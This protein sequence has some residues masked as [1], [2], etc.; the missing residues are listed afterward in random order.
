MFL[1]LWIAWAGLNMVRKQA[2]MMTKMLKHKIIDAHPDKSGCLLLGS[3]SFTNRMEQELK[4]DPIWFS[5]FRMKIKT[6]EKYLGQVIKSSLS[7]SALATAQDRAGKIK[8]AAIEIKQIIE[9]YQMQAIG[10]LAA[11]WVLWERAFIPSLLAGA[12]TWL[13]DIQEA[14][15][16]CNTIQEFYWKT[17]LKVLDSCPKLALRCETFSRRIKW[18]IWEEKCLLV[19]RIQNLEEGSLAKQIYEEAENRGWPGLGKE[20]TDICREIQIPNINTHKVSKTVIQ[21]AVENSHWEDMMSQFDQSSKL[22]DI[23]YCDF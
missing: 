20:V 10:G 15:K 3:K 17:V 22:Q 13:G 1:G 14:V 9:D 8:G 19:I 5:K 12:D 23:K 18:R 2:N 4:H 6:E 11:A 21:K 7:I 16:F